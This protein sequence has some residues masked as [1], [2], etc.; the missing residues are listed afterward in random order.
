MPATTFEFDTDSFIRTIGSS[1]IC[2]QNSHG[3]SFRDIKMRKGVY[4]KPFDAGP[5]EY[6]QADVFAFFAIIW[7]VKLSVLSY[8]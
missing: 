7:I 2:Q 8:A 3:Q 1:H 5:I 4:T 6:G